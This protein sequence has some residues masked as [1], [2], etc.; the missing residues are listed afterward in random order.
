[1]PQWFSCCTPHLISTVWYLVG[2][3]TNPSEKYAKV[4]LDHFP[5]FRGEHKKHIWVATIYRYG[6]GAFIR[7]GRTRFFLVS[8]NKAEAFDCSIRT[9]PHRFSV[10]IHQ[11]ISRMDRLKSWFS[12]CWGPE[13]KQL[14]IWTPS[15]NV[16]EILGNSTQSY[17]KYKMIYNVT[18]VYNMYISYY[19]C[20]ISSHNL[21]QLSNQEH[22]FTTY[23]ILMWPPLQ[24]MDGGFHRLDSWKSN[25]WKVAEK[26]LTLTFLMSNND[27]S[28]WQTVGFFLESVTHEARVSASDCSMHVIEL[29]VIVSIYIILL[30]LVGGFNPPEKY[31]RQ[32][33]SF[34]QQRLTIKD[35]WNHHIVHDV[36]T[37]VLGPWLDLS[38]YWPLRFQRDTFEN[39]RS[40]RHVEHHIL[41]NWNV[42]L[43]C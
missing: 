36:E 12:F 10:T 20:R 7:H 24:V 41:P 18:Y 33:G 15:Q 17:H 25:Q 8:P 5:N 29:L 35:I 39:C 42:M 38:R 3:W 32:I 31:A 30:H 4:K 2:G 14:Q 9:L 37:F 23:N 26:L 13:K 22:K 34:P 27:I 1:M 43:L 11:G 40:L 28:F 6:L 19:I 21:L 16:L